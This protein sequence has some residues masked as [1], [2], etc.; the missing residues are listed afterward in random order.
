MSRDSLSVSPRPRPFGIATALM[1]ALA[2]G[3][4][5]CLLS[6]YSR[7]DL[8]AFAFVVALCV[9]WQLR[10]NGYA[11]RWSGALI[12]AF[13]VALAAAYSF[14]LQAVAQVASMLGLPMRMALLQIDPSMAVDIAR[15]NLR[16]WSS[17]LV[18]LA[19]A[20]AAG[21]MLLS[22]RR[23]KLRDGS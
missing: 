4:I 9:V 18:L 16:G 6:L 13:C 5:W 12:A 14:Y 10:S 2:G 21:A 8:A 15:A 20:A 7:G 1:C 23:D 22:V 3:A 17:A 19:I 11:G